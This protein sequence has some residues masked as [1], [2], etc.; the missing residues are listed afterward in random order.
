MKKLS[1][2]ALV[3]LVSAMG[4]NAQEVNTKTRQKADENVPIAVLAAIEANHPG[5]TFQQQLMEPAPA[6]R[7]E[8]K[9]RKA[10]KIR[11]ATTTQLYQVLS[12]GKNYKKR[13]LYNQD[14]ALVYSKER[15][16]NTALPLVVRQ[17]IGREYNGWLI[18]R[19]KEM[20]QDNNTLMVS[21]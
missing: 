14:G 18:K 8:K 20:P 3:L 17:Y 12:G 2:I 5:L 19:D 21:P 7:K 15:I 16:R 4:A 9:I 6:P 13:E 1:L 11:T 10:K